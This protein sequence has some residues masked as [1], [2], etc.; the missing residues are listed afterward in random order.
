MSIKTSV[1]LQKLL[2]LFTPYN[3]WIRDNSAKNSENNPVDPCSPEA[4]CWC[5]TGGVAKIAGQYNLDFQEML[6]LLAEQLPIITDDWIN[7]ENLQ[8]FNDVKASNKSDIIALIQRAAYKAAQSV[9]QHEAQT[10]IAVQDACN[11]KGVIVSLA[12]AREVILDHGGRDRGTEWFNYHPIMVMYAC[13]I[14]DM[15]G[16]SVGSEP[17][18]FSKSYKLCQEMAD[19]NTNCY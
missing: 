8:N 18:T 19:G 2:E 10:A 15:C 4:T 17:D 7:E 9:L 14:A 3:S 1:A 13:K 6:R 12:N 16:L 11:L 5:L